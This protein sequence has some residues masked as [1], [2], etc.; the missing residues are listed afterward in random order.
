MQAEVRTR[1]DMVIQDKA[2]IINWGKKITSP[3]YYS[4]AHKERNSE[5]E[6][7]KNIYRQQAKTECE[8]F[9]KSYFSLTHL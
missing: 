7:G 5:S 9:L 3:N 8:D 2:I 6:K 1:A 4:R